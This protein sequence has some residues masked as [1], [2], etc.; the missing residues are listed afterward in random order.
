MRL[1]GGVALLSMF[2]VA[3]IVHLGSANEGQHLFGTGKVQKTDTTGTTLERPGRNPIEQA[4]G[5][6]LTQSANNMLQ[7]ARLDFLSDNY[8]MT[9]AQIFKSFRNADPAKVYKRP[10]LGALIFKRVSSRLV[11][12]CFGV[13]HGDWQC[14]G[15]NLEGG[16]LVS[17]Y[18]GTYKAALRKAKA[19]LH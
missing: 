19:R 15:Q 14:L 6:G 2:I 12:L 11:T 16:V 10:R 17:A 1:L 5:I 18:S 3:G 4:R 7:V 13:T 8:H 9:N